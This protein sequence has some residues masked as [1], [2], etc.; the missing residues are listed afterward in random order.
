MRYMSKVTDELYVGPRLDP[1]D[2]K[3]LDKYGIK[4]I[5][6]LTGS[7]IEG[8]VW[9]PISDGN[10]RKHQIHEAV[11]KLK[12]LVDKNQIPVYVHCIVGRNRSPLVIATYLV[13]YKGFQDLDKALLYVKHM[14]PKTLPFKNNIETARLY[15]LT[16]MDK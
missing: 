1:E 6:N 14:H 13:K 8:E 11:E 10:S 16:G 3:I 5:L 12:D 9:S 15:L 7:V 2:M 4:S